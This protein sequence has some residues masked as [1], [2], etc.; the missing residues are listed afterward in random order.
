[1]HHQPAPAA[2]DVQQPLAGLQAQLAADVV[3][4]ALLRGVQVVVGRLEVGARIDHAPVEPQRVEVVRDVVMVGDGR[5]VALDRMALARQ[6]RRAATAGR[7][8]GAGGQPQQLARGHQLLAPAGGRRGQRV[9][10][11]EDRFD[12]PD[13]VEVVVQVRL[14]QA[15]LV[16]GQ[17][18]G[19]QRARMLERQRDRPGCAVGPGRAVPQA[20]AHPLAGLGVEQAFEDVQGPAGGLSGRAGGRS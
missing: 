2:A 9:G 19:A 18:H 4:L 14:G 12:V 3:Q 6:P 17:E 10:Q 11:V 16:A 8:I 5:A 20:H 1:V 15:Q 7:V 13:D